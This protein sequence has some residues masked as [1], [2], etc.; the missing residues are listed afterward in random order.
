[1]G[2]S[3][4]SELGTVGLMLVGAIPYTIA[5][6]LRVLVAETPDSVRSNV[7]VLQR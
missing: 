6:G 3:L 2:S 1:M 4:K 5:L 7:L